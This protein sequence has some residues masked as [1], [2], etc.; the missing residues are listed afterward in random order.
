MQ[1]D[2]ARC[3]YQKNAGHDAAELNVFPLLINSGIRTLLTAAASTDG[4]G[5][6]NFENFC[7]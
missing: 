3:H 7:F 6:M 5:K 2:L 4:F 1:V